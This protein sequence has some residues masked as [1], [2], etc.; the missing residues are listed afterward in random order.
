MA[1]LLILLPWITKA[2]DEF[3]IGHALV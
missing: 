3:N 1:G 2:Y